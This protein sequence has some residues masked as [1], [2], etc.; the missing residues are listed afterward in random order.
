[1]IELTRSLAGRI[2]D[3]G[4]GGEGIIGRLYGEQVTAIDNCQEELEE[5]PEGFEKVV[6]DAT[7]LR[8]AKDSFDHV[9]FFYTLMFMQEDEQRQAMREATRV[10]KPG[11]TLHIWDCEIPSAYPDPFFISLEIQMPAECLRT[12]YGVVKMGSQNRLTIRRIGEE[13][14]LHCLLDDSTEDGFQLVFRK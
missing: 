2:L 11:G 13:S 3:I 12:T 4:G 10:L 6:M 5:A 7:A 1:M 14:G 8:Y 9:T